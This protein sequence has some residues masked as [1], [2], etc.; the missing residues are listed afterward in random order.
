M[1]DETR[2]TMVSPSAGFTARV[3]ARLEERERL[4]ARR[5]SMIGATLLVVAVATV[6]AL[7]GIW[8]VSWIAL[9][10]RPE[11]ISPMV[12]AFAT[13]FDGWAR[14]IEGLWIAITVIAQN[15][16]ELPILVYA[17]VVLAMTAL[18]VRVVTGPFQRPLIIRLGGSR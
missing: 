1:Q 8:L 6:L 4:Q 5:R 13:L 18:W 16:G 12:M 10:A 14:L 17:C 3:M 7:F 15:L 9:M 11:A 2:V